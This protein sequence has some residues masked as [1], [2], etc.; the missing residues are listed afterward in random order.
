MKVQDHD[1]LEPI[2]EFNQVFDELRFVMTFLNIL[3]VKKYHAV[4]D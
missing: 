3:G 2:L 4:S 1:F